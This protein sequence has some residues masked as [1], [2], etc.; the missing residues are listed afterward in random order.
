MCHDPVPKKKSLDH[1]LS[2]GLP[3]KPGESAIPRP[4][5]REWIEWKSTVWHQ[6][7]EDHQP[8]PAQQNRGKKRQKKPCFIWENGPAKAGWFWGVGKVTWPMKGGRSTAINTH[9][10][11]HERCMAVKCHRTET[12][13]PWKCGIHREICHR[14]RTWVGKYS[15]SPSFF[16]ALPTFRDLHLRAMKTASVLEIRVAW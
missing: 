7:F 6:R 12:Q 4:S 8:K 14:F 13:K 9:G 16:R 5:R 10:R 2:P 3:I 1:V 11:Y 15:M